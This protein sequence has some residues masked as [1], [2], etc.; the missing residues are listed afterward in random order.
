MMVVQIEKPANMT[1]AAW[2]TELRSWL[3]ENNCQ[4]ASFIPTGRVIDKLIFN[5]IF[6]EDAHARLFA[7]KFTAFAPT[8][9][10]ATSS[11]RGA[12]FA[13]GELGRTGL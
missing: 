6:A 5:A 1:L 3:D 10:R 7:A 12:I 11:E 8:I 2:F 13:W 9:R 4:P